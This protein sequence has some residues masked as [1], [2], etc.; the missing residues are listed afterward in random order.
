[1]GKS[2]SSI[3]LWN[4]SADKEIRSV[5]ISADGEYVVASSESPSDEG[6]DYDEDYGK[7]Y[8]FDKDSST[9]LWNY[10]FG[11]RVF[12]AISKMESSLQPLAVMVT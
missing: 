3:P 8:L 2:C 11:S 1:M 10:T 4:F 6:G 12:T 5:S 9:P 7:L